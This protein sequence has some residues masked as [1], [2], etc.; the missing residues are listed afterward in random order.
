MFVYTSGVHARRARC[1]VCYRKPREKESLLTTMTS[2]RNTRLCRYLTRR[3]GRGRDRRARPCAGGRGRG[4]LWSSPGGRTC[5]RDRTWKSPPPLPV[6]HGMAQAPVDQH[7]RDR[8]SFKTRGCRVLS[9]HNRASIAAPS[10]GWPPTRTSTTI[11]RCSIFPSER[12]FTMGTPDMTV[13]NEW[14]KTRVRSKPPPVRTAKPR[15]VRRPDPRLLAPSGWRVQQLCSV[16]VQPMIMTSPTDKLDDYIT[17]RHRVWVASSRARSLRPNGARTWQKKQKKQPP[18]GAGTVNTPTTLDGHF[19]RS[20][21]PRGGSNLAEPYGR[22]VRCIPSNPRHAHRICL[23]GQCQMYVLNLVYGAAEE[24][25]G[26]NHQHVS[27]VNI[28][29]D[30]CLEI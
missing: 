6:L 15:L 16:V 18:R 8:F 26:E 14:L 10:Q 12:L 5:P 1:Q 17:R 24:E 25:Q 29:G 4:N 7:V 11:L 30:K 19:R 28:V 2:P 3:A 21:L 22:C 13:Q 9:S 23:R 27:T 20:N